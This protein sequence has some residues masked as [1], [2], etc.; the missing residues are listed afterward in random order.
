MRYA[1]NQLWQRN[2]H[3]WIIRDEKHLDKFRNYIWQNPFKWEIDSENPEKI[4]DNDLIQQVKISINQINE[5][6]TISW[7]K[8][9]KELGV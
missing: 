9:K 8:A 7:E 6:K 4:I 3:E 5:G 2:Y 1:P